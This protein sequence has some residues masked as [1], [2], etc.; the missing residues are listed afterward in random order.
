MYP[1]SL[2][3]AN[4]VRIG[5]CPGSFD[6]VTNGHVDIFERASKLVDKLIVAV[7]LIR[8]KIICLLK[9]SELN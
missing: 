3:G 8:I 9:M 5:I 2:K 6:P 4:I 7:L 1:M